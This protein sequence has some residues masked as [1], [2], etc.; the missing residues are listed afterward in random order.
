[1]RHKDFTQLKKDCS[2]KNKKAKHQ[3]N[4]E[5]SKS[6]ENPADI[7]SDEELFHQAMQ[8]V[9]PLNGKARGRMVS[10]HYHNYPPAKEKS[11]P[12]QQGR[13]YLRDLIQG[14]VEF[15]IEYTEEFLHGNIKGLDSKIFKKLKAG[16][17]SP[18][19][20]LDLHG[21]SSEDAH[22]NLLLFMKENYLNGKRC[23]LLVPGRGKNSPQGRGILRA[24]IQS[25]LTRDPLKRIVLAFS[26]AKPRHGGAGAMYVLLRKFKKNQGKI[27]WE[28]FLLERDV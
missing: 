16:E 18:E 5:I 6:S 21:L 27:Y 20:H 12:E 22:Y 15:E 13:Q 23:L 24:N 17:F 2:K 10:L 14:K 8:D 3:G 4:A 25:W 1:M 26:T 11:N 28:K 19:S 7:S 9:E